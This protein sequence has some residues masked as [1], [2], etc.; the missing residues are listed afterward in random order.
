MYKGV[1]IMSNKTELGKN[2]RSYRIL[3]N[4]TQARLAEEIGVS[5]ST[6][7]MYETGQREPDM[8]MIEAIADILNVSIH[9]LV[10]GKSGINASVV[11]MARLE[12]MHQNPKLGLLFDRTRK[13]SSADVEMMLAL[14]ER[15]TGENDK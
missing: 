4:Y 3:R 6:I 15:I 12:A 11:D 10:P 2:I 1:N 5:A 7:A 13:M 8:D 14:S 9:D